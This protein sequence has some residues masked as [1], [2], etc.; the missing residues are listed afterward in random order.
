MMWLRLIGKPVRSLGTHYGSQAVVGEQV[1]MDLVQ[2]G[3]FGIGDRAAAS[4]PLAYTGGKE[5]C[6]SGRIGLTANELMGAPPAGST[7]NQR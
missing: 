7:G 3:F 2:H 1:K 4:R 5:R 6:E